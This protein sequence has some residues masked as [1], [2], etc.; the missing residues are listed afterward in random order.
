MRGFL[1]PKTVSSNFNSLFQA[2]HCQPLTSVSRPT[3]VRTSQ[4]IHGLMAAANVTVTLVGRC[5]P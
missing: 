3:V 5:A 2:I 4:A 1:C